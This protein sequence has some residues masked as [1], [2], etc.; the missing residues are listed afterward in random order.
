[1]RVGSPYGE[2]NDWEWAHLGN[3][4]RSVKN[5][6]FALLWTA[7][8]IN[9]GNGRSTVMVTSKDIKINSILIESSSSIRRHLNI[10]ALQCLK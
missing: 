7:Y 8:V 1:M 6:N 3:Y 4:S 9:S 2:C 5:P 10:E